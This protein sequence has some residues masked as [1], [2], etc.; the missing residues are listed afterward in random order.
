ML[1]VTGPVPL[2]RAT[3]SSLDWNP[4]LTGYIG[5]VLMGALILATGVLA[6]AMTEN[7]VVAAFLSFGFL[8]LVWLLGLLGSVL[9]DTPVGNTIA[10]LS[11]IDHYDRLVRGLVDSKD[12]IY[13]LSGIVLMLFFA[14]RV[15]DSQRWK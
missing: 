2:I 11:F 9:G 3:Y 4:I 13:Y 10:Y 15:V 1:A 8:L 12:L 14:H 5:L 6:S 7:Q